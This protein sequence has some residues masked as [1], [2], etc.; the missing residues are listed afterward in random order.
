[1]EQNLSRIPDQTT[2][3]AEIAKRIQIDSDY[4]G[5]QLPADSSIAWAGYVAALLEWGLIGVQPHRR[6][7]ELLP[8]VPEEAMRGI[9]LG[10]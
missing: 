7:M 9:F 3:D 8:T 10:R 1:M 5:G 4:F 2:L 6:L